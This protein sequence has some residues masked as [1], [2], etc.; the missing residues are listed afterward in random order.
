MN[1]FKV[2]FKSPDEVVDFVN[3]VEKYPFAMDLSRG[4]I[5]VDAKSLLGI[6]VLGLNQ[7]VNLRI[8]SDE[9]GQLRQDIKKFIAA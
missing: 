4:S 6:M 2:K 5:M 3:R 1:R 9:C 8:H 7:V